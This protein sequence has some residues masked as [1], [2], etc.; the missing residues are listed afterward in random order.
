MEAVEFQAKVKNGT[1]EIPDVYQP[2][3]TEGI[4][5]K[6]IVLKQSRNRLVQAFK[7]LLQ[8]TQTLPQARTITEAEIAAEIEAHRA[9]Q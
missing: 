1:I 8:E 5:V 3:L 7:S 9:G 6:V 2:D 4:Q